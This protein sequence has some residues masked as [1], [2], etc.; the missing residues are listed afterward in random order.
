[1]AWQT[2]TS[3]AAKTLGPVGK[4]ARKLYIFFFFLFFIII[5]LKAAVISIEQKDPYAGVIYL[6]NKI[7]YPTI[8]LGEA[9]ERIISE[10]LILD[11][12]IWQTILNYSDLF[13]SLISV[14]FWLLILKI[15]TL[16]LLVWDDSKGSAGWLI[17]IVLF[18]LLQPLALSFV[19]KSPTIVWESFR[20]FGK[21]LYHVYLS[22]S[23]TADNYIK[24]V[25][26]NITL[27][28]S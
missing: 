12:G 23:S 5:L 19:G 9:S 6:G 21:L 24:D 25:D 17:A 27:N 22:T 1:M 26:I 14:F 28:N 16:K 18:G 15:A 3:T 8:T 4:L 20:S 10:G 13:S 2:T 11:Q 7:V